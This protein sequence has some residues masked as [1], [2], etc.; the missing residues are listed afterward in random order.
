MKLRTSLMA[1][2]IYSFFNN[3]FNNLSKFCKFTIV[4][5]LKMV[6]IKEI[7]ELF[8][9][10]LQQHETKQEGMFTKREKMVL[11]PRFYTRAFTYSQPLD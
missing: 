1:D 2:V 5:K 8:R 10:M 6:T 9:E 7:R 4:Y 11:P 3:I